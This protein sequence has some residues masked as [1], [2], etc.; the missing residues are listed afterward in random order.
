MRREYRK[1]EKCGEVIR[2][3]VGE[4]RPFCE[5]CNE[6]ASIRHLYKYQPA[7]NE[8]KDKVYEEVAND[9]NGEES[10]VVFDKVLKIMRELE[11]KF[12]I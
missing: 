9:K 11:T 10:L 12:N 7:W 3:F 2:P 6:K 4:Y 8:L 1:C 5:K